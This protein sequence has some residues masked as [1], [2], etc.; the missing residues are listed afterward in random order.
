MKGIYLPGNDKVYVKEW[1]KPIPTKDQ[2]LIKVEAS[3]LCGTEMYAYHGKALG[4][5]SKA[6]KV[7]AGHEPCGVVCDRGKGVKHLRENDRVAITCF[8]GCGFCKYCNGGEP[9]LCGEVKVLGRDVNG[10]DAEYLA[11]P[12]GVCLVMPKEMDYLT[13]ALATDVIGNLY[14]TMTEMRVCASDTIGIV[15]VGPM[16][17]G[18]VLVA[19]TLGAT[20]I[21]MDPIQ[22][23]LNAAESLGADYT[24]KVD[25]TNV[26]EYIMQITNGSGLDKVV[27]CS[28]ND[29]GITTALNI[30]KKHGVVAQIGLN[31]DVRINPARHLIHKKLSYVGS[32]YFNLYQW[33]EISEF[34]INKIGNQKVA[35]LI[36]HKS[37]LDE[38]EVN[39]VFK[40]FDSKKTTKVVFYPNMQQDKMGL[41]DLT[42]LKHQV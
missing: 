24:I 22:I 31:H 41:C 23:R 30:A 29:F 16:G 9:M 6:N 12:E 21:A 35:K 39:Q 34:I 4:Q 38:H 10:G 20:V 17:L 19:K 28:G 25:E 42:K 5:K 36:S 26:E 8:I 15:G 3:A 7:I 13:G 27:E 33:D 11:V 18:G 1:P 2:V 40:L 37:S 32:W 14:A